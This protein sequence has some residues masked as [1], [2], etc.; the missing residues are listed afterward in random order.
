MDL[1]TVQVSFKDPA[2]AFAAGLT[3]RP[4]RDSVAQVHAA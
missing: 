1:S 2:A 4:L 3:P